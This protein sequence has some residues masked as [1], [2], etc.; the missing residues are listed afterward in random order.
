MNNTKIIF[1]FN[2]LT[3][4]YFRLCQWRVVC[5]TTFAWTW[6]EGGGGDC[7]GSG[8]RECFQW[9]YRNL[10]ECRVV[11]LQKF[12]YQATKPWL[13]KWSWFWIWRNQNIL[14]YLL[15]SW[16]GVRVFFTVRILLDF[17]FLTELLFRCYF[18][19]SENLLR[20]VNR[21]QVKINLSGCFKAFIYCQIY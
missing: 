20:D 12:I 17:F 7:K 18:G 16:C 11:S 9:S 15:S 6:R 8:D 5:R 2:L 4:K 10:M 19:P 3:S 13:Y 21:L 14:L 1:I